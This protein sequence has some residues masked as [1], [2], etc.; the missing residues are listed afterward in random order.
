[1]VERPLI[2]KLFGFYSCG[3]LCS[4]NALELGGLQTLTLFSWSLPFLSLDSFRFIASSFLGASENKEK[5]SQFQ[6]TS[7]APDRRCQKSLFGHKRKKM[8]LKKHWQ[9]QIIHV[10][11]QPNV[12]P[13]C[14]F[15]FSEL[16]VVIKFSL[17]IEQTEFMNF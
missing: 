16:S 13:I 6:N 5:L 4:L 12:H 7:K 14:E 2:Q 15:S 9:F 3:I 17:T 8:Q 10:Q 11:H 1:M